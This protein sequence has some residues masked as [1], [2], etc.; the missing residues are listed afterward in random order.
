MKYQVEVQA[1]R[2]VVTVIFNN[3][4]VAQHVRSAIKGAA[5]TDVAHMPKS[6]RK[7][8]E[9]RS[10]ETIL[11][12]AQ[13]IGDASYQLMQAVVDKSTHIDQAH[14]FLR[15]L[16]RLEQR[17][18][19]QRLNYACQQALSIGALTLRSLTSILDNGIDRQVNDNS[20]TVSTT[21]TIEEHENLR[22]Q[23]YFH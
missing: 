16:E 3:K 23:Q 14:K 18:D 1:T 20:R 4:Q 15:G 21:V 5:S 12:N 9:H 7:Q 6:H 17:F 8:H 13:A 2:D 22:G 10:P 11:A 19:R